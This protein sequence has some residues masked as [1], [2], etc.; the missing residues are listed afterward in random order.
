MTWC[1]TLLKSKGSS[2]VRLAQKAMGCDF[3]GVRLQEQVKNTAV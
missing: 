3:F 1:N 2:L